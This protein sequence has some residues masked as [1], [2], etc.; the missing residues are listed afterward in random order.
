MQVFCKMA[1][2][3]GVVPPGW[4]W[5]RFLQVSTG[6]LPYAFEK[7][8][9]KEKWGGENVFAAMMGGRSL[10]ATAEVVL[11]SS[12]MHGADPDPAALEVQE[13]LIDQIDGRLG[14]LLN[15]GASAQAQQE[16][17][18]LLADVGGPAPW[19]TLLQA[20]RSSVHDA[21]AS[22]VHF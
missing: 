14:Q 16:A 20:V 7:S 12:C 2:V 18:E 9:A 5:S 3:N 4:D 11:G 17:A 19:R 22:G 10:R 15:S 21:F 1:V 8:D 13:R 6:L